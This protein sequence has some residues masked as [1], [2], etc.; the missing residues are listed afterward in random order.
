ML[1]LN[2]SI[3]QCQYQREHCRYFLHPLH[4]RY[5]A[6]PEALG[7]TSRHCCRNQNMSEKLQ[8]AFAIIKRKR[9]RRYLL[10]TTSSALNMSIIIY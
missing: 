4:D 5:G 3:S 6:S 9:I 7:W 8:R 10:C 1:S 2:E